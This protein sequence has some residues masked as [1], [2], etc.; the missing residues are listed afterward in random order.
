MEE[1]SYEFNWLNLNIDLMI[2]PKYILDHSSV[3]YFD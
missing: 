3:C 1:T 2:V